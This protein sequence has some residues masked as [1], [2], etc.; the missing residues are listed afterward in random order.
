MFG[1]LKSG[2]R[3]AMKW[4]GVPLRDPAAYALWGRGADTEAG[5]PVDEVTSLNFSA[6]WAAVRILSE[7][8]ASLPISVLKTSPAEADERKEVLD[9]PVLYTLNIAPNDAMSAFTFYETITAH[10]ITWGNGY[11]RIRNKAGKRTLHPMAPDQVSVT[12]LKTGQ[13]E[14][15]F[16]GTKTG[17]PNA[18]LRAS[19][20]LHIPG[21]S[22]DGVSG[23]SVV[24]LAAESIGLGLAA[25]KS[26]AGFFGRGAMPS[27]VLTHPSELSEQGK[28]TLRESWDKIHKGPANSHRIAVLDEGMTFSPISI[29]AKDAQFLETRQFQVIEIA[30]W[31]NI[32]PH[33]LRDL[34]HA[35]YSNI[36]HQTIDFLVYSL[37]PW[38]I[39]W[40][41]ELI[42][43]LFSREEQQTLTLEHV[44]TSLLQTDTK[45][46]FEAFKLAREG[47]WYTVN[48]ILRKEGMNTIGPEG[49][50]YLQ[51]LN[52]A[53]L[54]DP[55][56]VNVSALAQVTEYIRNQKLE[57][58]TAVDLLSLVMPAVSKDTVSKLASQI[59]SGENVA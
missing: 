52:M 12:K 45:S 6:V 1:W 10:A 20:V 54:G 34:T 43:K 33:M 26:G 30:R 48:N 47:G 31:F 42:R 39:R 2:I 57:K 44:I 59:V 50:T 23:Y 17:E 53:K 11:A 3:R 5:I 22:F 4:A 7:S 15:A 19:E 51:P 9:H 24:G 40:K 32:P 25:E 41:Q 38:L 29:P 49:D 18:V 21:L 37:R 55:Q 8:V 46:R 27:G 28:K 14:Y 35:T 36:E 56:P 58:D 13:L 16:D